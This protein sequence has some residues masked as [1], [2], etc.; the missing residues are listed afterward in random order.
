M[1]ARKSRIYLFTKKAFVIHVHCHVH[2]QPPTTVM[3]SIT[4]YFKPPKKDD[5][6]D[7]TLPSP[8]GCLSKTVPSSR[9]AAANKEVENVL[10]KG[11]PNTARGS[12]GR[13]LPQTK[14]SVGLGYTVLK[15]LFV[16]SRKISKLKVVDSERLEGSHCHKRG[17]R[18]KS[19]RGL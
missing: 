11:K 8:H 1:I 7:S 13:Y 10:E 19:S 12:Y 5:A 17:R 4:M 15:P 9:I 3:S 18:P 16:I 14:A 6:H 2:F